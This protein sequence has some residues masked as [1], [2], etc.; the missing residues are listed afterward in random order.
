M[1]QEKASNMKS[2]KVITTTLCL[3]LPQHLAN[4]QI[5]T[6]PAPTTTSQAANAWKIGIQKDSVQIGFDDIMSS[7]ELKFN[8][9]ITEGQSNQL[10]PLMVFDYDTCG[11]T[12][13]TSDIIR[14]NYDSSNPVDVQNGFEAVSTIVDIQTGKLN[15]VQYY[16]SIYTVDPDVLDRSNI[17]FCILADLGDV[18]IIGATATQ[19][20]S[21]SY[22]KLRFD[23]TVDMSQGFDSVQVDVSETTPETESVEAGL[24]YTGKILA[25]RAFSIR[26]H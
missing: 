2:L 19:R 22:A 11:T 24:S 25:H 18:E 10:Q 17:R 13:Y 21:V 14:L 9:N 4:A 20:S 7:N 16:G 6:T 15:D 12:Q 5:T 1:Y 3:T 26:N 8:L 23:I